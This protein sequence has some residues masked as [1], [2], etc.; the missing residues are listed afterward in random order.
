MIAG[1][2]PQGEKM[3]Y[4]ATEP[5]SYITKYT[6]VCEDKI[7]NSYTHSILRWN[8]SRVHRVSVGK[9]SSSSLLSSLELSDTQV[10]EP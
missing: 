2:V 10:Y 6:L 8:R 9:I 5:E 1:E 7:A 3:L 4:S